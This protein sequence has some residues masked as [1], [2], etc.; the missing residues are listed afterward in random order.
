MIRLS[1]QAYRAFFRGYQSANRY[2]EAPDGRRYWR[3]R[4]EI[5]RWDAADTSGLRRRDERARAIKDWDGPRHAPN[6]AG[7]YEQDARGGWWPTQMA[8]DAGYLPCASCQ[9]TARKKTI[10]A[11]PADPGRSLTAIRQAQADSLRRRAR[12]L[13]SDELV[14]VVRS[15]PDAT[16]NPMRAASVAQDEP[17]TSLSPSLSP[18][19]R[20]VIERLLDLREEA[21]PLGS[22]AYRGPFTQAG[23]AKIAGVPVKTVTA[24]AIDRDRRRNMGEEPDGT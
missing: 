8:L 15:I 4:Y 23:I 17:H 16:S 2:W 10:V 1:P 11:T 22:S 24:M 5:D 12:G 9:K 18:E 7:L 21:A 13:T 14:Q 19:I 6:G 3:A 20:G